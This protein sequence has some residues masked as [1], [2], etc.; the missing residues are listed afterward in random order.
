[1]VRFQEKERDLSFFHSVEI[2]SGVQIASG[3]YVLVTLSLGVKQL[4]CET[5]HPI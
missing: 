2:I 4:N 3:Q 1:M 5:D